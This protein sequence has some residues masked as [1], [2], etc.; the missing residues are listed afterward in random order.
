MA[1]LAYALPQTET[2][3]E[4]RWPAQGE[5]TWEDY[6]RLPDDGQRYEIIEGVL[7]VAAAPIF[8]HQFS[9]SEL[10][11]ELRSFVK[12]RKLGRKKWQIALQ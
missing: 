4:A 7:Y 1:E 9:V 8:D 10:F 6:L 5:W 2:D 11:G 12:A 3:D